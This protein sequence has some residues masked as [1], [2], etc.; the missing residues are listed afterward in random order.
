MIAPILLI[1]FV[2]KYYGP[3]KNEVWKSTL[4]N[5]STCIQFR[6]MVPVHCT[7]PQWNRSTYEVSSW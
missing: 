7:S 4:G 5:N 6:A 1:I 3:E 2:Y